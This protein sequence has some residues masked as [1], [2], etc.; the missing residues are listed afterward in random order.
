VLR[1]RKFFQGRRIRGAE[2]FDIAWLDPSGREM[3]D[4]M[5]NSPDVRCLGVRLNGDAIDEVDERGERITGDS[6]VLLLNAGDK[7]VSFALPATNPDER[8]ETLIDTAD[9][10]LPPRR[11]SA[12][13][14][15][16]LQSRSMVVLKLNCRKED[17]RRSADWGPMGVY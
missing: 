9:P 13:D 3:T 15:Y 7:A 8:W 17:L 11:L 14:R 1:R 10:W 12:R 5:W 16:Q 4:Q 2:V 6:L